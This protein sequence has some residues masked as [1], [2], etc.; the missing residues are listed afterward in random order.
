M[1]KTFLL[2]IV[3]I[4]SLILAGSVF[5]YNK[6]Q[7]NILKKSVNEWNKWRHSNPSAVI[8]LQN[9]NLAGLNLSHAILAGANLK[10]ANLKG[11]NLAYANLCAADLRKANFSNCYLYLTVL[12]GADLRGA[13]LT[14]SYLGYADLDRAKFDQFDISIEDLR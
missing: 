8:D 1:K 14:N 6:E 12:S 13:N 11:C 10:G 3:I 9:A 2:L 5:S 7:Y 4:L